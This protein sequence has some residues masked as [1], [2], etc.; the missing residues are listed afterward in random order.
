MADLPYATHRY[1]IEPVSEQKHMSI[2]LIQNFMGFMEK[3]RN[4]SK[5]ILRMLYQIARKDVKTVTG[6]NLR[7]ILCLTDL[8]DVD[9][10]DKS[11]VANLEYSSVDEDNRWR[12]SMVKELIDMKN[13]QDDPLNGWE[14]EELNDILEFACF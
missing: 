12:V 5:Q 3:I 9:M 13:R 2:Q 6:S 8:C 7:V 14:P 10:L 1:L 11:S 4:S